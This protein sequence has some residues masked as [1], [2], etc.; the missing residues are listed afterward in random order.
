MVAEGT[1]IVDSASTTASV[2]A[3]ML[4]KEE[5]LN[6]QQGS[7]R[8]LLMATDGAGRFARV[9]GRFIGEDLEASD[10]EIVDL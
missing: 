10:I 2:A 6:Q 4:A 5:L 3:A 8:L 1:A 9:G 7:G